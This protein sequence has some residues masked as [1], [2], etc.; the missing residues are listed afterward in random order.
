M[1]RAVVLWGAYQGAILCIYRT[2]APHRRRAE[3]EENRRPG[4]LEAVASTALFFLL[5]CFGWLLFRAASVEQMATFTRS[6]LTGSG[7]HSLTM[8]RPSLAAMLGVSILVPYEFAQ[9]FAGSATFYRA[10]P[11]P[12]RGIL[13]GM[14]LFAI[15]MGTS[16]E[17]TQFIYFQF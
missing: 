1:Q 4:P 8:A 2:L 9:H 6:L 15:M 11:R 13:Y 12:V 10:L 16:N 5:T 3:G 17:P 7:G 14:L